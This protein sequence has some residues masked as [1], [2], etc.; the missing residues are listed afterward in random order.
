MSIIT[1]TTDFGNK[2][3]FVASVKGA[4][5]SGVKNALIIDISHEIQPYNHS[6]AAYVLKNAYKT[7]PK[8]TIHIIGV[9]SELTPENR[10]IAMLFEGHYFI[11]SDNGIFSMIKDDLKAEKIVEINIH[12]NESP[13][14]YVLDAFVKVASHLSR[15]G[16]LEV[17]GKAIKTIKQITN[18]NPVVNNKE[19]QILG[20]VIYIDNYGNVVT[21]INRR[22]FNKIGKSRDYKIFARTVKFENIYDSY[23][24][25]IDFS[26]PKEKREEDGKKIAI[27][28][29][30]NHLELGIY[31]SNPKTYGSAASLFGLDYRDP[32]TV[33]FE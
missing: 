4:I 28:N 30:A 20:S 1:L 10:H 7:F 16:K 11:G 19:N 21:N 26:S 9:E 31:K 14:F 29:S 33:K 17:I 15:M 22:F 23:T 2:D 32:I 3:F 25:A 27:F 5:L 24:D 6:E 18:I 12:E 8:G 13:S